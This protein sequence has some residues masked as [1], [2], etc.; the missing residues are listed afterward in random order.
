MFIKLFKIWNKK[1][2]KIKYR[3]NKRNTEI[4]WPC[5]PIVQS[6]FNTNWNKHYFYFTF[7]ISFIHSIYCVVYEFQLH[8]DF[9]CIIFFLIFNEQKELISCSIQCV[10][11]WNGGMV[12]YN[13]PT[14]NEMNTN[15]ISHS[16]LEHSFSLNSSPFHIQTA[17]WV[18]EPSMLFYCSYIAVV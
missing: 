5:P 18:W 12:E 14:P 1:Y 9:S 8:L 11:Q 15:N 13:T 3:K 4:N 2:N 10:C 17:G 16:Q 6:S 7:Y